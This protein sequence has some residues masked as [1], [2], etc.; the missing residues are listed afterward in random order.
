MKAKSVIVGNWNSKESYWFNKMLDRISMDSIGLVFPIMI[1]SFSSL[2][3]FRPLQHLWP[4]SQKRVVVHT[5]CFLVTSLFHVYSCFCMQ[6]DCHDRV[7]LKT[8]LFNTSTVCLL[9]W[10]GTLSRPVLYSRNMTKSWKVCDAWWT[11][12]NDLQFFRDCVFEI[13]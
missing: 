9:M 13:T 1:E 2:P 10:Q 4:M 6:V 7:T 5:C 8:F 12:G 11:W 3:L